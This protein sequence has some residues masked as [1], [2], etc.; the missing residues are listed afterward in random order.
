MSG[1]RP[2]HSLRPW[3]AY[4]LSQVLALGGVESAPAIEGP[5]NEVEPDATHMAAETF[6]IG[7]NRGGC[8]PT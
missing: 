6:A 8:G 5:T 7:P 4:V 1:L 3:I 2:D